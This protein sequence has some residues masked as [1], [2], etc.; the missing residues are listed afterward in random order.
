MQPTSYLS[1]SVDLLKSMFFLV[2]MVLLVVSL[3]YLGALGFLMWL[4]LVIV[5]RC[6]EELVLYKKKIR[7]RK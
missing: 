4:V 3:K 5:C 2:A 7:I 1:K 6:L